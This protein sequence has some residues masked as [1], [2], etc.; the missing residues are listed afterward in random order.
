MVKKTS[1]AKKIRKSPP[2]RQHTFDGP[3]SSR[4]I[5]SPL[6]ISGVSGGEL[7]Q[8]GNQE[9]SEHGEGPWMGLLK[10]PAVRY[11]I[12]TVSMAVLSKMVLTLSERY[13]QISELMKENLA[14]VE[15]K[16]AEY[17]SS[18]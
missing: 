15:E 4:S 5:R 18:S 1:A 9:Q 12:A 3:L 14:V 8:E 17:Q 7:W 11:L 6:E 10:K 16:L 13:P 2:K